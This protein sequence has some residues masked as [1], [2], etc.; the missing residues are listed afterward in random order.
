[1]LYKS[2]QNTLI[3]LKINHPPPPTSAM[4]EYYSKKDAKFADVQTVYTDDW[5]WVDYTKKLNEQYFYSDY[6]YDISIL[7]SD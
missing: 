4:G 2:I 6:G 1:L 7:W 3:P 5:F